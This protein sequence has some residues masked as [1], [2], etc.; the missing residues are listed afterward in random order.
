[1]AP[2]TLLPIEERV[3]AG[4]E[5]WPLGGDFDAFFNP[6]ESR[7]VRAALIDAQTLEL[8]A[9]WSIA[10][11]VVL[12]E[13]KS[14]RWN[15]AGPSFAKVVERL[16]QT[17][18]GEVSVKQLGL[19]RCLY[20][21]RTE[22]GLIVVAEVSSRGKISSRPP[23]RRSSDVEPATVR[24]ICS[25][26]MSESPATAAMRP[27]AAAPAP[28]SLAISPR[29]A[30][31]PWVRAGWAGV[32]S[33][34]L[35]AAVGGWLFARAN[36]EILH[37]RALMDA[38]MLRSLSLALAKSDYDGVQEMLST[39]GDS[40]YFSQAAVSNA[41]QRVIA[42]GGNWPNVRIGEPVPD[43]IAR[44]AENFDLRLGSERL[45]QLSIRQPRTVALGLINSGLHS[46]R[47]ASAWLSGL[48]LLSALT[49]AAYLLRIRTFAENSGSQP[50]A[51]A[52][53]TKE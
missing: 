5:R 51:A 44:V 39:Y 14:D 15:T 12:E 48:A 8:R 46:L 2:N 4:D 50:D 37:V 7:K 30:R 29:S 18:I 16:S 20:M 32:V 35:G 38:A 28:S 9:S 53:P 3:A 1:M 22:P 43:E 10:N 42:I 45:G 41:K 27:R 52:D 21:W 40:G 33:L 6:F 24:E 23:F 31:V 19:Q 49:L 47:T 11:C 26:A 36:L 25:A 13:D 34:L 17:A